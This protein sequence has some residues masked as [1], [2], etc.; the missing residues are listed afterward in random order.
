MKN[1]DN[2]I[3][4]RFL[5]GETVESL[6]EEFNMTW[7]NLYQIVGNRLPCVKKLSAEEEHEIVTKY[8]SGMSTTRIG[9]SLMIS[10]KLVN[11]ILDKY[12]VSRTNNG[13]RKWSLKEDY[14]DCIDTQNK[15]YILGFLYADGY[16]DVKKKAI[17][18]QLRYDD[19]EILEKINLELGSNRPLK[20]INCSCKV[21]KNG[22]VSKDMYSLE[23]YGTHIC[24]SLNNLGMTQGKSLTLKFPVFLDDD[25]IRHFIRGYFDGDGSF[26]YSN[27]N[28]SQRYQGLVTITS[29]ENFCLECLSYIRSKINVGGSIFDS[30]CHNGITKVIS[31]GGNVQCKLFLDWLYEDS[32]MY[33]KRKHDKYLNAYYPNAA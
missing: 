28:S 12:G 29:T 4:K 2:L 11:K 15:A 7:S 21:A 25:L 8:L 18:L 24:D 33:L 17:R 23:V 9:I 10:H 22:F 31:I 19:K 14:F 13:V 26:S 27:A 32:E 1:L 3:Y 16:N 20:F 6:M 30:S 5:N